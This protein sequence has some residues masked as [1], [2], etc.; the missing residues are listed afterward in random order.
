MNNIVSQILLLGGLH[1]TVDGFRIAYGFIALWMWLLTGVFSFEYFSH[2]REHLKRYIAFTLLTFAATEGVMFSADL[3]TTFFFF[4]I[5]SLTS[6]VWV[7]HEETGEAIRAA[8]TYFFIAIIGGLTLFMGL[9]LLNREVGTLYYS[10]LHDAISAS[11]NKGTLMAAGICIL[12][13]FG[14]KAGMFPLHIWLPKSHPVAPSPASALLSGILTK[15]GIFGILMTAVPGFMGSGEFSLTFGMIIL[16]LGTITMA[17]GALL[18]LFSVNLKRTLACSSMSQIGFILVGIGTMIVISHLSHGEL[19]HEVLHLVEEAEELAHNGVVLHMVNHSLIKLTLFMA[20]GVVVMNL[21]KLNLNEIRGY[22]RKKPFLM[23]PFALGALGISGIPFFSGYISKTLLHEGLVVA[24]EALILRAQMMGWSFNGFL[25]GFLT[26]VEWIF[27][28]SGGFTF[29]YMLKLFICLFIEK[30][31]ESQDEF[32]NKKPYMNPVSIAVLLFSALAF[33]LLG[34]PAIMGRLAEFMTGEEVFHHFHA[35]AWVNLKGAFISLGIGALVYVFIVRN[36]LMKRGAAK[37]G[38]RAGGEEAVTKKYVDLWPKNI[39]LEDML[40]RPVLL[41]VLPGIGGAVASFF[42]NNT[43]TAPLGK[44]ILRLGQ[45]AA[46]I[47]SVSLDGIIV[48][49][50]HTLFNEKKRAPEVREHTEL[51]K[52]IHRGKIVSEPIMENFSFALMMTALGTIVVLLAILLA[53]I[54]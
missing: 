21:H 34:Q 38:E 23:I 35:F 37:F 40:Y 24:R 39:D 30:N 50:R 51:E 31:H 46:A 2:E 3:M 33:P 5:L 32:D 18:A 9:A 26:A 20:A 54:K 25:P 47:F 48:F 45:I 12:L 42:A 10:Q 7:I 17:L 1:F 16:I 28:I 29:A 27:L 6:F 22:G 41:K 8:K 19:P 15:V 53:T 49:M 43:I 13:G 52:L 14:A 11:P 36:V 4:E 44:L